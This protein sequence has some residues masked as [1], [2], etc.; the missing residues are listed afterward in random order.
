MKR[1]AIKRAKRSKFH[2][3]RT[4]VGGIVFASKKEASRWEFLLEQQA[5]GVIRDLKR[6]TRWPLL[7]NKIKIGTYIDD[8]NYTV[9]QTTTFIVE[10]SKSVRTAK[11][12]MYRRSKKHMLA[13]YSIEIREV[14]D[15]LEPI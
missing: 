4:E 13:Q 1:K 6:Q 5:R 15:P 14:F 2:N 10:D 7:V 9:V 12:P 8:F 11:L 3:I